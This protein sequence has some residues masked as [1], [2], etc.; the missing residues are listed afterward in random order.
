MNHKPPRAEPDAADLRSMLSALMDGQ[1]DGAELQRGCARWRDDPAARSTWHA[2]HLI[3]DVLRSDELA[4]APARDAAFLA[5]LRARLAD[6]PT[7]LAPAPAIESTVAPG[8]SMTVRRQ[9][10][11]VPVAV[12]AGFAVVA[13]MLVVTRLTVTEDT[14][15]SVLA[16]G[17]VTAPG[18]QRAGT[19]PAVSQPLAIDGQLIRDAHLDA[20]LRAHREMRGSAAA[21]VPG[22]AMRS[23]ETIVP[24][25]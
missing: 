17:S 24:Q 22:G 4:S 15:A 2:Y 16:S 9:A 3:G 25:R 1:S 19:A 18:L 8:V 20:Y 14:R 23:V 12:A 5:A 7:V 10:W 13:G 6:E 11:M 21:A